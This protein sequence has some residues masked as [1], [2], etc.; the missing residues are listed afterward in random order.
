MIQLYYKTRPTHMTDDILQEIDEM[1][2]D[3]V[4]DGSSEEPLHLITDESN[5]VRV[6][7]LA[8]S[9]DVY[10]NSDSG[11]NELICFSIEN[12]SSDPIDIYSDEY[13]I[14]G[15]DKFV[16]DHIE[17]PWQ[18][19]D[20]YPSHFVN[21]YDCEIP[22]GSKVRYLIISK[23]LPSSV[24]IQKLDYNYHSVSFRLEIPEN[25]PDK[26]GNPPL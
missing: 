9:R 2:E 5:N 25:I 18:K 1:I 4:E 24:N 20:D 10:I 15:D 6:E 21:E 16:Y 11:H 19:I 8:Y 22:S 3:T 17:R 12:I 13:T 26:V 7:L 14:T 23:A